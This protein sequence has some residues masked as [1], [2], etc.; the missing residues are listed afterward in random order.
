MLALGLLL[1]L[2]LGARLL[3]ETVG[4]REIAGVVAI[5]AGIALVAWA[6]RPIP[7]PTGAL[8]RWI[9]LRGAVPRRAPHR[10][11]SAARGGP[12]PGCCCGRHWLC[13]RCDKCGDEATGYVNL[14]HWAN[15]AVWGLAGLA[16][17]VAATLVNMTAFQCRPATTVATG[18]DGRS[19][20]SHPSYSSQLFLHEHWGSAIYDGAPVA[21]GL[22][23][24][25][26]G[27]VLLSSSAVV[28]DVVAAAG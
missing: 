24:A 14:G 15:A 12:T 19:S 16:V 23:T 1:V 9:G 17:G 2:V 27:I 13:V 18:L 7:R 8:G 3:H 28:T 22:V 5:I 21:A 10:S 26:I 4:S 25:L 6:P 20:P 11:S